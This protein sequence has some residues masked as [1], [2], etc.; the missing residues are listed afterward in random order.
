MA[1]D[2]LEG[3]KQRYTFVVEPVGPKANPAGSQ[4]QEIRHESPVDAPGFR[5][6][7]T[8][9]RTSKMA[10]QREELARH[11]PPSADARYLPMQPIK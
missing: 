2:D 10:R 8:P 1:F 6:E 5:G 9:R 7:D 11:C 3:T 4:R